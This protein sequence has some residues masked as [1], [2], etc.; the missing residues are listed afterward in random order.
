M[1]DIS[2]RDKACGGD[3]TEPL[4]CYDDDTCVRKLAVPAHVTSSID[5][6]AGFLAAGKLLADFLADYA[7]DLFLL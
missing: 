1:G 5:S 4:H 7:C 6:L 3:C 2:G